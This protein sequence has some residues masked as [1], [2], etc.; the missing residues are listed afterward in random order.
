MQRPLMPPPTTT[1]ST[2]SEC[3]PGAPE[4]EGEEMADSSLAIEQRMRGRPR[5]NEWKT[6]EEEGVGRRTRG[7]WVRQNG[8]RSI[9]VL[10][11]TGRERGKETAVIFFFFSFFFF[12][13]LSVDSYLARGE[14]VFD[15]LCVMATCLSGY[16]ITSFIHHY[17]E[18]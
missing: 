13:K 1:Q 9:R 11:A 15:D 7:H 6:E 18:A 12:V 17:L 2:E 10:M 8:A 5:G 3:P 14:M 16:R 4:V